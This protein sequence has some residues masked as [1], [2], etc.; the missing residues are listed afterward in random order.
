M[1]LENIEIV[2]KIKDSDMVLVGLGKEFEPN[3][4]EVLEHNPVY[5]QYK[6]DIDALSENECAWIEYACYY[7]ELQQGNNPCII[8]KIQAMNR[9]EELIEG[10]NYFVVT[11]CALDIIRYSKI[12][13]D[14]MVA[15]CGTVLKMECSLGCK[16]DVYDSTEILEKIYKK[17]EMMSSSGEFDKSYILSFVP[18]CEKCEGNMEINQYT[19][20]SYSEKAY[21]E[22][23]ELYNKWLTGTMNKNLVL[24]ELGVDFTTPTVIR[25]PFEKICLINNKAIL[26]RV[27]SKFAM[28]TPEISEKAMAVSKS[29]VDF[30]NELL[31]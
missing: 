13:Q 19:G 10:K 9:I 7:H 11:T 21:L 14:R 8:D 15:P 20:M 26:I 16:D 5:M 27:N 3:L 4:S 28:L 17:L 1:K 18:I 6:D 25:W 29:S 12:R 31:N 24:L 22:R 30:I 2:Q 23:W